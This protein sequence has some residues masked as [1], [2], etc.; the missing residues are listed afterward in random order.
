MFNFTIN[1]G[2]GNGMTSN[3]WEAIIWTDDGLFYWHIYASIG[4]NELIKISDMQ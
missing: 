3:N 2:P 4:L 1:I